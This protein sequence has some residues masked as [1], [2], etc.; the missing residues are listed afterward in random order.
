MGLS[1]LRPGSVHDK[2]AADEAAFRWPKKSALLLDSG[3]Q[4]YAPPGVRAFLPIKK[5][6]G[7]ELDEGSKEINRTLAKI[8]VAV[9]HVLSGVKRCGIVSGV[10][11]NLKRGFDHAAM[12][13]ACA[14]HN[15]RCDSRPLPR[16]HPL[17]YAP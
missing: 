7:K 8:R 12:L 4:G 10:F 2:K 5:P 3:F 1:A 13:I 16:I 14:L 15:F 9:E 11:R 17:G 6:K